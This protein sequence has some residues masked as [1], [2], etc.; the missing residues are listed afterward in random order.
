M[1]ALS[2]VP[3]VISST[4]Q[5][6][7]V[8]QSTISFCLELVALGV[9]ELDLKDPPEQ[10]AVVVDGGAG[11]VRPE[12]LLALGEHFAARPLGDGT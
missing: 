10:V 2:F 1:S 3:P 11:E 12:P 7:N 4:S 8:G 6:R 5:D 9:G